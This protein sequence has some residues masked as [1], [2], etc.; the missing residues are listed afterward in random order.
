MNSQVKKIVLCVAL[1]SVAIPR[2]A[3]R[4]FRQALDASSFRKVAVS[5]WD[6]MFNRSD[7]FECEFSTREYYQEKF[8]WEKRSRI[9]V[10]FPRYYREEENAGRVACEC[11]NSAYSFRCERAGAEDAWRL[12]SAH[13]LTRAVSRRDWSLSAEILQSERARER[14]LKPVV[15]CVGAWNAIGEYNLVSLFQDS[16]FRI[17]DLR[18]TTDEHGDARIVLKFQYTGRAARYDL[19]SGEIELA[20]DEYALLRARWQAPTGADGAVR[21]WETE[22]EYD[23]TSNPTVCPNVTKKTTRCYYRGQLSTTEVVDYAFRAA[24]ALNAARFT[25]DY[26]GL[27]E[28]DLTAPT[29]QRARASGAPRATIAA[30]GAFL[31][32]AACWLAL[33]R[34]R[35]T[36]ER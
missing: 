30:V 2:V 10:L 33:R 19:E 24:P 7:A 11:S 17:T 23:R 3:A 31:I 18:E 14:N 29:L 28:P 15:D 27:P 22:W 20:R 13:K 26:Y 21:R 34:R 4:V 35:A 8:L 6:D 9:G 32:G 25:T 36:R 1:A 5:K 12:L 16:G